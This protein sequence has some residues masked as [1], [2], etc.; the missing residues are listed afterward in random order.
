[1]WKSII[2]TKDLDEEAG[3]AYNVLLTYLNRHR[4]EDFKVLDGFEYGSLLLIY[5]T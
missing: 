1:M 2:L 5:R 3:D 4:V